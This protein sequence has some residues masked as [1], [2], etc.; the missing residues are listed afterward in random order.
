VKQGAVD[1]AGELI[2]LSEV[3]EPSVDS[4]S[5]YHDSAQHSHS[6]QNEASNDGEGQ[7]RKVDE[8]NIIVSSASSPKK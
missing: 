2:V 7:H 1:Q 3:S 5:P 4:L 8:A 6:G